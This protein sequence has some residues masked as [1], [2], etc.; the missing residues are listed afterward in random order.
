VSW[1]WLYIVE[2]RA[3]IDAQVATKPSMELAMRSY[4][5]TSARAD[6]LQSCYAGW[7][8]KFGTGRNRITVSKNHATMSNSIGYLI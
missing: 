7:S 8:M 5:A 4:L 6:L 2:N 1:M 3:N